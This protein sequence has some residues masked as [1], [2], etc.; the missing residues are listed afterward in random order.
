MRPRYGGLLR[1]GAVALVGWWAM[2]GLRWH[3]AQT[4]LMI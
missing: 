4:Y 2:L 3:A 1:G